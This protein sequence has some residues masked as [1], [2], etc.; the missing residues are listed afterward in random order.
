MCIP[1]PAG[2][3]CQDK[4]MTECSSGSYSLIGDAECKQCP[5]GFRCVQVDLPPEVC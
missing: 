4:M 3:E 2:K 5:A 1:C